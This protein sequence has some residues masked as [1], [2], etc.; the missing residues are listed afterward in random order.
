MTPLWK[1]RSGHFAGWYS[2][3]ALYD[4]DGRNVG[5]MAGMTAY[6]LSGTFLGEV[7]HAEWIGCPPGVQHHS[8]GPRK[9]RENVAHARL[10]DRPPLN[11][12]D[13]EDPGF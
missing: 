12:T 7:T 4:A 3:D 10:A 2:N 5:Y 8:P 11:L 13:W 6:A 9:H 1:V